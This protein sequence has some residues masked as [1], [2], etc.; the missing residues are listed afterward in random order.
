MSHDPEVIESP[1]APGTPEHNAFVRA[2][3]KAS[4]RSDRAEVGS[5][6]PVKFLDPRRAAGNFMGSMAEE[7]DLV[8]VLSIDSTG[9]AR[10][11]LA[12]SSSATTNRE[13]L[14][15]IDSTSYEARLGRNSK[16]LDE[17]VTDAIAR[18]RA[19]RQAERDRRTVEEAKRPHACGICRRRYTSASWLARHAA[20]SG[21]KP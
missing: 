5:Q 1:H 7:P 12:R 21:H 8:V 20:S 17:R 19:Y 6:Q 11:L 10:I 14:D 16:P 18:R 15:L 4:N 13:L 3:I 9:T 2:H